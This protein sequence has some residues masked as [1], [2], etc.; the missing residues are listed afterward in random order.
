MASK[1]YWLLM[2]EKCYHWHLDE[3]GGRWEQFMYFYL[4]KWAGYED[5]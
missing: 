5:D 4:F 2:A 3:P 1:E